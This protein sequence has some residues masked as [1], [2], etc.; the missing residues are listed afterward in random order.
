MSVAN[1]F[2]NDPLGYQ[3]DQPNLTVENLLK[4]KGD[5][6]VD[7]RLTAVTLGVD[8]LN[9]FTSQE[10]YTGGSATLNYQN[11]DFSLGQIT[12]VDTSVPPNGIYYSKLEMKPQL[13]DSTPE[14]FFVG[15]DANPDNST[16]QIG[17]FVRSR[18]TVAPNPIF[19]TEARLG[20][21]NVEPDGLPPILAGQ[22]YAFRLPQS[23][24]TD[25]LTLTGFD[26]TGDSSAHDVLV[27]TPSG[28]RP[29]AEYAVAL[30]DAQ[31]ATPVVE[32]QGSAGNGQVYDSVYNVPTGMI[33]PSLSEFNENTLVNTTF[34]TPS[35]LLPY[36]A[37]NTASIDKN[38]GMEF[39]WKTP[40]TR[41]APYM[42]QIVIECG[43]GTVLGANETFNLTIKDNLTEG[44]TYFGGDISIPTSALSVSPVGEVDIYPT[45][46]FVFSS[47]VWL[48]K[49]Q[50]APT[51]ADPTVIFI[52]RGANPNVSTSVLPAGAVKIAIFPMVS[53]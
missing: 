41:T 32:V 47:V 50:T 10:P 28:A 29:Y 9:L 48:N 12:A 3:I 40:L 30:G 33:L 27:V 38:G 43:A 52:L 37:Q 44:Q 13:N 18:R 34:N 49:D 25:T 6:E 11:P 53:A 21:T 22:T 15:R 7:G 23:G 46:K 16:R 2:N 14:L 42:I 5:A 45:R 17:A 1:L 35:Y 19:T 4:V 51:T 8:N 39:F 36:T 26:N 31:S 20:L 24:V